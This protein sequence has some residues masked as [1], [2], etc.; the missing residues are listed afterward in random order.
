MSKSEKFNDLVQRY[1]SG[2][3]TPQERAAIEAFLEQN[4][5]VDLFTQLPERE[6]GE[7]HDE[8]LEYLTQNIHKQKRRQVFIKPVW[9]KA[10]AAIVVLAVASIVI[11]QWQTVDIIH[12]ATTS[13]QKKVILPDGS[14]IWMK[15]NS[16]FDYPEKF[17]GNERNVS[18]TGEVF[19]E[20][21]K[22]AGH[23][24]VIS[25]SN[26]TAKVLGTSFNLRMDS[27]TT[28]LTVLTGKV[29]LNPIGQASILVK[30]HE[31]ATYTKFNQEIAIRPVETT[32][33]Q[34]VTNGTEYNMLF[35][36]APLS[37]IIKRMEAKFD[38]NI[39][40]SDER[41]KNCRITADFT[42]QSLTETLS[43]I[44]QTFGYTYKQEKNNIIMQGEGCSQR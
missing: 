18:F 39:E 36:A 33:A 17:T 32:D 15:A 42:D 44:G 29:A 19:F 13:Q 25:G 21:A 27:L 10:A 34:N 8:M 14:I 12:V 24:F 31:K 1:K 11:W 5:K 30:A 7:L 9:L 6:Q 41:M 28:E 16:T 22:D 20:V 2:K 40:V 3:A 43:M 26:G 35:D 23:P 38:V 4:S 37:Q